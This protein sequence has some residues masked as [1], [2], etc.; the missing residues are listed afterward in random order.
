MNAQALLL[1][2][3]QESWERQ[4]SDLKTGSVLE[5]EAGRGCVLQGDSFP[6][7]KRAA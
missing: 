4:F 6:D 3:V 5:G 7:R 1:S 2:T